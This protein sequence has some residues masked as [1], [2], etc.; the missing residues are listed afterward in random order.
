MRIQRGLI[1][2]AV[3]ALALQL[4]ILGIGCGSFEMTDYFRRNACDFVNCN[5]LFWVDDVFPL[6][7]RA[8]AAG[9]TMTGAP[10]AVEEEE[11]GHMH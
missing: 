5:V 6:S 2:S 10:P 7:A 8:P 11:S 3:V 1:S 4:T 9:M